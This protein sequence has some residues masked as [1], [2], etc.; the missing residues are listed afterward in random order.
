MK[1]AL[2]LTVA[3]G[4]VFCLFSCGKSNYGYTGELSRGTKGKSQKV[5][6]APPYGMVYI[7]H[8]ALTIGG[9]DQDIMWNM[10]SQPRTITI[11]AFWMDQTE[12]TNYEYRQ[13]IGYVRDSIMRTLLAEVD[14]NFYMELNEDEDE[15]DK[16]Q[17]NWNRRINL[18]RDSELRDAVQ[19]MYYQ[20]DEA[21]HGKEIDIRK[22]LYEYAWFD[23][24]QA[25]QVRYDP[26]EKK[27]NGTVINIRGEREEVKDRSSF[28][29][30]ESAYVYPDTLCWIRDF[31]FSFNE[32]LATRYFSHA[33]YNDY[34]VVGVSWKQATA[35]CHWRTEMLLAG[36]ATKGMPH[37]YRLPSEA[38]WEYAARGGLNGGL[39]PWGGPYASDKQGCYLANFKPQRG[40]YSLDGGVYTSPVGTYEPNDY[41]LYDMAGNVAE[42]TSNTFDENAYAFYNDL[43]P[44]YT[45]N[46]K[47]SDP[48]SMKRKVIRGGSWKDIAYY[49][50]C[51]TRTFE[52]QDSTK[53]YIG[54]RC[55]RDYVGPPKQEK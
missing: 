52:Y 28:I 40:R 36:R 11:N 26:I 43:V 32:P 31:T 33:A 29:M 44:T 37:A 47:A 22:L 4:L 1:K 12:I 42:W 49:I 5:Q 16:R 55:I 18:R 35:F 38:E 25:A 34:P 20:G 8:G 2:Y 21:I 48:I 23:F 45:T 3:V 51:G 19:D 13:F 24:H 7:P 27:Y 9:N 53:S 10:N 54:F 17:L 15:S 41:G 46:P 50:Q 6:E 39:Y 14:D 30:R